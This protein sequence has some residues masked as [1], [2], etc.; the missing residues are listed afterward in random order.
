[1]RMEGARLTTVRLAPDTFALAGRGDEIQLELVAAG[2]FAWSLEGGLE[3]WL[4]GGL[5][6]R[7][8]A[9]SQRLL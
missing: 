5:G 6:W 4:V 3:G 7:R 2:H 9:D 8:I 1:M